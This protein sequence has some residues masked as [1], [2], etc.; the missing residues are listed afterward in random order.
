MDK[1]EIRLNLAK[2]EEFM[3]I[4][5]AIYEIKKWDEINRIRIVEAELHNLIWKNIGY[6]EELATLK[7]KEF[8]QKVI[9]KNKKEYE[10]DLKYLNEEEKANILNYAYWKYRNKNSKISLDM[11]KLKKII[12]VK[13][14][15]DYRKTLFL[16]YNCNAC[17]SVGKIKVLEYSKIN[18]IE[19]IC[20][21]CY[22][23]VKKP[24]NQ[25]NI[26]CFQCECNLCKNKVDKFYEAV[27]KNLVTLLTKLTD[28]LESY[29]K[30]NSDI[31]P[32]DEIMLEDWVVNNSLIGD[33]I[34]NIVSTD[35]IDE[36]EFN[37]IINAIFH[38]DKEDVQNIIDEMKNKKVIYII[39]SFNKKDLK[40]A[41]ING[42][43][44]K[45]FWYIN[46]KIEYE[47]ESIFNSFDYAE[48]KNAI[49]LYENS[50]F[51]IYDD[52]EFFIPFNEEVVYFTFE[53]LKR[54]NKMIFNKYFFDK[55]DELPK[56]KVFE[57][58]KSLFKSSKFAEIYVNLQ[59]LYKDNVIFYNY[60]LREMMPLEYL[61][62]KL[63]E[64]VIKYLI[65]EACF[66][67]VMC[68]SRGVPI[69]IFQTKDN[70]YKNDLSIM[71]KAVLAISEIP[72]E[73]I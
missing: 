60:R 37:K 21:N 40:Q 6:I 69:K 9:D 61:Q 72:Y 10:E 1:F 64:K 13:G 62:D 68:D 41:I 45:E 24:K 26:R 57:R 12:N 17:G 11:G 31:I 34:K 67:F 4:K 70:L 38:K 14:N 73:E 20:N 53:K 46:A 25:R 71:I 8:L 19:F 30:K 39:Q 48:F 36:F 66:D 27:K 43:L 18:E 22:H 65:E 28:D 7:E 49:K 16:D 5:E 52:K 35:N 44:L 54:N 2:Y 47:W 33:D 55:K 32:S 15:F 63:S 42:I 50:E 3:E 29:F 51:I 23:N 58:N 59:E 56:V